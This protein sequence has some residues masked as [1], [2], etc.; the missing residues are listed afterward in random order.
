VNFNVVSLGGATAP[1]GLNTYENRAFEANVRQNV[2][3]RT[4]LTSEKND[5][6]EKQFC[7]GPDYNPGE[8]RPTTGNE[9]WQRWQ[10]VYSG[11]AR[12]PCWIVRVPK[13]I[14]WGHGGLWSDNS[15]AMFGA[16]YRMHFPLNAEGRS[17]PSRRASIPRAPDTQK[18]NEDKLH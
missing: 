13:E 18:L 11:N 6:H 12:V 10:F 14:I 16:L 1:A 3:G 15:V 9:D 5:G 4:F 8:M 17:V 7:R 2:S